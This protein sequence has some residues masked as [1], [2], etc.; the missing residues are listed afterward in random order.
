METYELIKSV[1]QFRLITSVA[2]VFLSFYESKHIRVDSKRKKCTTHRWMHSKI[3]RDMKLL[4]QCPDIFKKYLTTNTLK[5]KHATSAFK[6]RQTTHEKNVFAASRSKSLI[7]NTYWRS[8]TAF[9]YATINFTV[10]IEILVEWCTRGLLVNNI[11]KTT[12]MRSI[13][14]NMQNIQMFG[15]W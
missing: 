5:K 8:D 13:S 14:S 11:Q 6:H 10:K 2:I 1:K 4:K 9:I 3:F 7:V 15:K 12:I